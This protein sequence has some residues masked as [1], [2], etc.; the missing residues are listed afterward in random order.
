MRKM[1]EVKF[2]VLFMIGL[3]FIL[4]DFEFKIFCVDLGN[5]YVRL[6]VLDIFKVVF[7]FV[8][9]ALSVF[10]VSNTF[11]FEIEFMFFIVV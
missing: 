8:V 11:V 4:N 1:Y 7:V 6:F 10:C 5:M 3:I 9:S 2:F